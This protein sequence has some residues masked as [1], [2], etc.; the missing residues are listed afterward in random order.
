MINDYLPGR[1]DTKAAQ[2]TAE[3]T[4]SGGT[5]IIIGEASTARCSATYS[6]VSPS[7]RRVRQRRRRQLSLTGCDAALLLLIQHF[8]C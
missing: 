7:K 3:A 6:C 5:V 4:R 2:V 8:V 1:G